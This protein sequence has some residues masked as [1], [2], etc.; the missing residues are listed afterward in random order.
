M[1]NDKA[2]IVKEN[3]EMMREAILERDERFKGS[4]YQD[5]DIPSE[6]YYCSQGESYTALGNCYSLLEKKDKAIASY[7]MAAKLRTVPYHMSFNPDFKEFKGE[8]SVEDGVN[9]RYSIELINL[10]III[11]DDS[12]TKHIIPFL[13][14]TESDKKAARKCILNYS[15]ALRFFVMG[16]PDKADQ[17]LISNLDDFTKKP[18]K[19]VNL[20]TNYFSLSTALWGIVKGDQATFNQGIE[21]QLD[22]YQKVAKGENKDT[23]EEFICLHALALTKL[24]IKHGLKQ[25]I[26]DPFI[27]QILI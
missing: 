11:N 5:E 23:S 25:E 4:F 10:L 1:A 20:F 17:L 16:E 24:A 19:G 18:P 2:E 13:L 7:K 22:L 27:P 3:L 6:Y 26:T 14:T 15:D 12:L 21:K 9:E 8:E